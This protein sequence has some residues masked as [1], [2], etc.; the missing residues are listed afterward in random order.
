LPFINSISDSD[1]A[2]ISLNNVDD[3]LVILLFKM[4]QNILVWLRLDDWI[5]CVLQRFEFKYSCLM[6]LYTFIFYHHRPTL[7]IRHSFQLLDLLHF[8]VFTDSAADETAAAAA[9]KNAVKDCS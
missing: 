4:L 7:V 9:A 5:L 6:G 3:G 1:A 8:F 2:V